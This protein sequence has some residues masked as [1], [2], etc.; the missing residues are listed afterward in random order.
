MLFMIHNMMLY[1]IP[2]SAWGTRRPLRRTSL[3]R[4]ALLYN[5]LLY[6]IIIIIMVSLFTTTNAQLQQEKTQMMMGPP[7]KS[8]GLTIDE[9]NKMIDTEAVKEFK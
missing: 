2:S 1:T 9:L 7:P 6:N 3:Y 5:G 4:E 8:R